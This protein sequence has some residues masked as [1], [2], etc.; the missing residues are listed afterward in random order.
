[1][2]AALDRHLKEKTGSIRRSR[3]W[4]DKQNYCDRACPNT[5]IKL[6]KEELL[7]KESKLGRT[8]PET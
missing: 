3:S 6:T 8:T 2:I 1:M 4:R 5:E 7:W